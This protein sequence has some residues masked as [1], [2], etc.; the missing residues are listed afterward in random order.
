MKAT[1]VADALHTTRSQPHPPCPALSRCRDG[2]SKLHTDSGTG[3]AENGG[4]RCGVE[5]TSTVAPAH[6]PAPA[7]AECKC[8][9]CKKSECGAI[10]RNLRLWLRLGGNPRL[11]LS[12]CSC[13]PVGCANCAQGC[14]CKGASEKCSRRAL[15]GD[16]SAP[17]CK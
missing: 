6:A 17:R 9:S 8:T 10:S 15:C 3:P 16:S 7:S 1:G 13:C 14:I 2:S 12:C 4:A 5:T 11:A